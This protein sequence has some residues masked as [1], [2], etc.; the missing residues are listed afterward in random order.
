MKVKMIEYFQGRE[1]GEKQLVP[2]S[3]YDLDDKLALWLIEIRKARAVIFG[4]PEEPSKPVQ[5]KR[6]GK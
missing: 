6:R 3:V 5:R 2:D 1:T 4:K